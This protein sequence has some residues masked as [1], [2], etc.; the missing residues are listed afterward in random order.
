MQPSRGVSVFSLAQQKRCSALAL[1]EAARPSSRRR[2]L[3][4]RQNS[5][6]TA[7]AIDGVLGGRSQASSVD[8][9][10]TPFTLRTR[11]IMPLR[12]VEHPAV[13]RVLP[14]LGNAAYLA[15]ASGFVMTDILSLRCLLV[16]G[17][18][19]LVCFHLLHPRPLRIPL[20][21][22]GLFVAVNAAMVVRLALERWPMGLTEGD[23][24]VRSAFFER[25]TPARP[26]KRRPAAR[27]CLTIARPPAQPA[28]LTSYI[29]H[30]TPY[31]HLTT[32]T[33]LAG[34]LLRN[35]RRY[36]TWQSAGSLPTARS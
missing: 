23:E 1:R 2:L 3:G 36:W 35:L 33:A 29:L 28:D 13:K 8:A 7:R 16:C 9:A 18:S 17:Y 5:H 25:C 15:L 30:I 21:W 4:Q 32:C 27:L 14:L 19:G 6:T 11:A 10:G 31:I 22:S 26:S 12:V 20:G 24:V 34:S